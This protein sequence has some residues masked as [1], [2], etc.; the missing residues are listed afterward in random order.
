MYLASE[1]LDVGN[2]LEMAKS[3]TRVVKFWFFL[4]FLINRVVKFWLTIDRPIIFI[5]RPYFYFYLFT[6][7][8]GS[9]T[10]E[11]KAQGG[12]CRQLGQALTA[13]R[14]YKNRKT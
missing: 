8:K 1:D 9:L 11:K 3:L 6:K 4:V 14:N 5:S 2:K 13:Q 12:K 10:T 7:T